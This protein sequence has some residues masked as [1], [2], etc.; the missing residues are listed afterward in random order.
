MEED[1]EEDFHIKNVLSTE[2]EELFG[3]EKDFIYKLIDDKYVITFEDRST[4][5]L[6]K[7]Y[8]DLLI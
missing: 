2:L 6:D 4:V 8:I 7:E 3:E 1:N 5:E